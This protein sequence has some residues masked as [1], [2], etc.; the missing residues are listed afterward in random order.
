M[1]KSTFQYICEQLRPMLE[2]AEP[3]LKPPRKPLS[4][5]K[6]VAVALYYLASCCEYRVVGNV[7]GI[8]KSTVWKCLHAVIE[9]INTI[10]LHKWIT[11]PDETECKVISSFYED[12]TNIPQIIGAL[13]GTHIPI[14][15]PFE[16]YRDYI[17]RK[18]WSSIVLQAVV[19]S[20]LR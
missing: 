14:L 6:K 4:V 2:P 11:M 7:F 9:A 20:T 1:K 13:D 18:G 10:L 17:N 3:L 5:E 15:P 16:G 12:V 19:D 8:H